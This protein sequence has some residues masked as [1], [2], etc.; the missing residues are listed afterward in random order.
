MQSGGDVAACRDACCQLKECAAYVMTVTRSPCMGNTS[1]GVKSCCYLKPT[2]PASMRRDF[3]VGNTKN[4]SR[5][6]V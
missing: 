1:A 6:L 2:V 3:C 5:V 4:G